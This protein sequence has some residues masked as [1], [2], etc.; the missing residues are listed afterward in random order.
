MTILTTVAASNREGVH[1][2]AELEREMMP[3]PNLR[4]RSRHAARTSPLPA[5][6]RSPGNWLACFT[7][8]AS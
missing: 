1:H 4:V 7:Q 2:H 8:A 3:S 5:Y 6:I